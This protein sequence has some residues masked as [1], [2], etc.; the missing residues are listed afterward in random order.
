MFRKYLLFSAP[1]LSFRQNMPLLKSVL[2]RRRRKRHKKF[3]DG[4]TTAVSPRSCRL[5]RPNGGKFKRAVRR[6][7][8]YYRCDTWQSAHFR[9]SCL[10]NDLC[11][12]S[13]YRHIDTIVLS[14][15]RPLSLR[16]RTYVA[17]WTTATRFRTV[18]RIRTSARTELVGAHRLL[19]SLQTYHQ[20]LRYAGPCTDYRSRTE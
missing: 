16:D 19:Y 10:H 11:V 9:G 3:L 6:Q 2:N 17:D 13:T 7:A 20:P 5:R 15:A 4:I 1:P 14:P 18:L 8:L 12:T